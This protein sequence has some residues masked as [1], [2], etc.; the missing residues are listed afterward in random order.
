M[1]LRVHLRLRLPER[2]PRAVRSCEDRRACGGAGRC[3][4]SRAGS[5]RL[6]PPARPPRCRSLLGRPRERRSVGLRG[7]VPRH[8]PAAPARVDDPGAAPAVVKT[9][10][11]A[12]AP[13]GAPCV[14]SAGL[15]D[16]TAWKRHADNEWRRPP[17]PSRR[18]ASPTPMADRR[19]RRRR[20][21]VAYLRGA[22]SWNLTRGATCGGTWRASQPPDVTGGAG[23]SGRLAASTCC[24]APT[25]PDGTDPADCSRLRRLQ[26]AAAGRRRL[27][28]APRR[29]RPHPRSR[30]RLCRQACRPQDP[31]P[32]FPISPDWLFADFMA[33][34]GR[35]RQPPHR[36]ARPRL[37][38]RLALAAWTRAFPLTSPPIQHAKCAEPESG[39]G[40]IG[41]RV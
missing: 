6:A 25:K 21:A 37:T 26:P 39:D 20:L 36:Q 11:P 2:T 35:G 9:A 27:A 12:A 10:A 8:T 32:H 3:G 31:L 24:L 19:R 29:T 17:A 34:G 16:G 41:S 5:T 28:P 14:P 22:S 40:I 4:A 7:P 18:P 23:C 13:A 1:A 15:R 33:Q 30:R 38:P